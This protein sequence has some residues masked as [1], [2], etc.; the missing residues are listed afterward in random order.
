MSGMWQ[1]MRSHHL[2]FIKHVGEHGYMVPILKLL[3]SANQMML[4]ILFLESS[5]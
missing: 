1:M 3:N 2:G 5:H 4:I